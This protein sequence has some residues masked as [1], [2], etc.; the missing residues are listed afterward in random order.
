MDRPA[1]T[2]LS[3]S[4]QFEAFVGVWMPGPHDK[5]EALPW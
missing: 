1:L 5:S 3:L 4:H 2:D